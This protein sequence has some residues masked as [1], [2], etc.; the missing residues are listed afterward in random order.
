[1]FCHMWSVATSRF[2]RSKSRVPLRM[3]SWLGTHG[4]AHRRQP[5]HA[6]PAEFDLLGYWSSCL[7]AMS[8]HV[9][10]MVTPSQ[11][12]SIVY[13]YSRLLKLSLSSMSNASISSCF[14]PWKTYAVQHHSRPLYAACLD[15]FAN[16]KNWLCERASSIPFMSRDQARTEPTNFVK[17]A[18]IEL[19]GRCRRSLSAWRLP[20]V[21]PI[22]IIGLQATADQS[23]HLERAKAAQ[24][25]NCSDCTDRHAV[26]LAQMAILEE[27][28]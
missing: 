9:G 17:P 24:C 21:P 6:E 13:N 12:G 11:A 8:S 3:H 4:L 26:R 14:L 25:Q 18:V 1:M 7:Y 16:E 19:D 15:V 10:M 27:I 5:G 20:K 23:C 28:H 22:P 2:C